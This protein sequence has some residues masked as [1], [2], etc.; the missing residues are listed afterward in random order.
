MKRNRR[1]GKADHQRPLL[2]RWRL[3]GGAIGGVVLV[4]FACRTGG[5][6]PEQVLPRATTMSATAQ[7]Y[8]LLDRSWGA[9]P[10]EPPAEDPDPE[11]TRLLAMRAKQWQN[12]DICVQGER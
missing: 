6:V 3:W 7:G 1:I 4:L 9:L 8:Q 2:R 11:A 10:K 5:A 12:M